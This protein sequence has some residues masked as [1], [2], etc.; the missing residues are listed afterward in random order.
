MRAACW[1]K[2]TE[3]SRASLFVAT[4]IV[5]DKGPI[6]A[7][8]DVLAVLSTLGDTSLNPSDIG[9][10]SEKH[11]LVG[12]VQVARSRYRDGLLPTSI[13]TFGLMAVDEVY[14]YPPS[15][16][17][18][19]FNQIKQRFPTAEVFTVN[20]PR[21]VI[22]ERGQPPRR[23]LLALAGKVNGTEFEGKAPETLYFVGPRTEANSADGQL[24]FAHRAEGW[25]TLFDGDSKQW[26]K[27]V[28]AETNQ[29]LYQ[30][31]DFSPLIELKSQQIAASA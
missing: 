22:V 7:Y 4:P 26:R 30:P 14:V 18:P 3:D 16:V 19:G 13:G 20:V 25:N 28:V 10:L 2:P 9:L 8:R 23:E 17:F 6:Q 11:P 27:V 1:V 21:T 15:E 24:V 31:V 12:D 5:D 29:P